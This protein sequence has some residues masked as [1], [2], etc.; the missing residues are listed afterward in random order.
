MGCDKKWIL[1]CDV[2][3]WWGDGHGLFSNNLP[4]I[5][6]VHPWGAHY[7]IL[8]R[9]HLLC[10]G[11]SKDVVAG[12]LKAKGLWVSCMDWRRYNRTM[13]RKG[14][15]EKELGVVNEW[16]GSPSSARNWIAG[17]GVSYSWE[18]VHLIWGGGGEC[19]WSLSNLRISLI[20]F[21][22]VV[23]LSW[24]WSNHTIPWGTLQ[25]RCLDVWE[26]GA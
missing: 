13:W 7:F 3:R 24:Y 12:S 18:G 20:F 6:C 11:W 21:E 5:H 17:L 2:R 1:H 22:M 15:N 23:V 10:V 9:L 26:V 14:L 16:K 4:A 19:G 8:S 25:R